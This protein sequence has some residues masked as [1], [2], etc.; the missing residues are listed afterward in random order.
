MNKKSFIFSLITCCSLLFSTSCSN[1]SQPEVKDELVVRYE[2]YV[3]K[4]GEL[5]YDEWLKVIEDPEL[6]NE[7][8]DAPYIG[9]NGNWYVN[10][11]DT[12]VKASGDDGSSITIVNTSLEVDGN[13]TYTKIEFSDGSIIKIPNGKD[14]QDGKDGITPIIKDGYW[15]NGDLNTGIKAEGSDG[16]SIYVTDTEQTVEENIS[17][18]IV[19]FSD[20]T[21]IKIPNGANGQDG[22]TPYIKDDYWY[23][24]ELNTN[25]KAKGEDG[26]SITIL[27]VGEE[28]SDDLTYTVIYFS[29]D[30]NIKIPNGKDG[31]DGID[32]YTPYIQDGYWYINGESTGVTAKGDEVEMRINEGNIEW[33]TSSSSD[34]N[35]LISVDIL[36]GNDGLNG[37]SAYEIYKQYC[38][39]EG[40]EEE[41]INDLVSGLLHFDDPGIIDY[42]PAYRMRVTVGEPINLPARINAIYSNGLVEEVNVRWNKSNLDSNYVGEKKILGYV[43]NYQEKY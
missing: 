33:K 6:N 3:S 39:Y 7:N 12:G 23:I 15:Y 35:I 38:N 9:S 30:T 11:L 17:Y 5:T 27:S 24:G 42:I 29:D 20:G 21:S 32:G 16:S 22:L 36:K 8:Y 28:T 31:Q 2:N 14:G 18:T 34:W 4:G 10:G 37:K 13:V 1:N 41:W 43:E 19:Y 26:N 25:V 40:S